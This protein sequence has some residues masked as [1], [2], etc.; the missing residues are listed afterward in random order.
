LKKLETTSFKK[1][2]EFSRQSYS[3]LGMNERVTRLIKQAGFTI[4]FFFLPIEKKE[5][6]KNSPNFAERYIF[7]KI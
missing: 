3:R 5:S 6:K 1:I 7:L 4:I 2:P